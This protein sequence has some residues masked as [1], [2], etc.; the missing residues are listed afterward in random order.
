M[1]PL[2]RV[3]EAA[4]QMNAWRV[5]LEE[6]VLEAHRQGESLRAI[7]KAAGWSY[8]TVRSLISRYQTSGS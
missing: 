5:E 6:A 8:E 7:G 2:R 1:N 4:A 3:E